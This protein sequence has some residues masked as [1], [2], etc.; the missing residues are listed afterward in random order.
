MSTNEARDYFLSQSKLLVLRPEAVLPP[1]DKR[2]Y[3]FLID[4]LLKQ[5]VFHM[6]KRDGRVPYLMA[7]IDDWY[8][9]LFHPAQQFYESNRISIP[10]SQF[11]MEWAHAHYRNLFS[12][13]TEVTLENLLKTF[14]ETNPAA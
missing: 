9:T 2:W 8:D 10:F 5:H 14:K 13:D 4:H 6:K 11:Y 7:L 12:K 1:G 3:R